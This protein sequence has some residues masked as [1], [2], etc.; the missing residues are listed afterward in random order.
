MRPLL[1]FFLGGG[2]IIEEYIDNDLKQFSS[3]KPFVV[4]MEAF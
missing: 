2:V 4:C 3:Q 1:L